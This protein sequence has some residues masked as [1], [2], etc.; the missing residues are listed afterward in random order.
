ME[1]V[2]EKNAARKN[3]T[4]A[5]ISNSHAHVHFLNSRTRI[6]RTMLFF[7]Y[8]KMNPVVIVG[9]SEP[10]TRL[11]EWKPGKR[12][13]RRR[14]CTM[15]RSY[16]GCLYSCKECICRTHHSKPAVLLSVRSFCFH[17]FLGASCSNARHAMN[18]YGF[19]YKEIRERVSYEE[20]PVHKYSETHAH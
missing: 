3:Q 19:T 5:T 4:P 9:S 10:Q 17:A 8:A 7:V 12:A 6:E 20:S 11:Q 13:H 18:I 15:C 2:S 14:K 16:P 1:K